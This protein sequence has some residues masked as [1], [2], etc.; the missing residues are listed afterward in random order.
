MSS[1]DATTFSQVNI[2]YNDEKKLTV[3]MTDHQIV[4]FFEKI[5]S[6][7]IYWYG[8]QSSDGEGFW[9]NIDEIRFIQIKRVTGKEYAE[10]E[11]QTTDEVK[12]EITGDS[13]DNAGTS[14]EHS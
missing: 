9:T 2:T 6:K 13:K 5:N 12:Q 4:D 8:D 7:E 14:T 11:A 3:N 1:K 10:K